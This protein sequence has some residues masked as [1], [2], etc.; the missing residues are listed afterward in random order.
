MPFLEKED[1]STSE[2]ELDGASPRH[3]VKS[4]GAT[5]GIL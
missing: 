4:F 3:K 2:V 1:T 5:E